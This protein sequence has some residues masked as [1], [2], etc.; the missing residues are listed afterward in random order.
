MRSLLVAA[1]AA[2][3]AVITITPV[4]AAPR[5]P[6]PAWSAVD[7]GTDQG[8]RGLAAVNRKTAWVGGSKGGVWRTTDGG[9]SWADVSPPDAAGLVFRDVEAS[10]AKHAQVLAI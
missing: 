9:A 6:S 2:L 7:V 8:L 3:L 1:A 5:S 10:D 4:Q